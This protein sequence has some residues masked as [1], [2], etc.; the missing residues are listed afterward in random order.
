M[1]SLFFTWEAYCKHRFHVSCIVTSCNLACGWSHTRHRCL[2][3]ACIV[4]LVCDPLKRFHSSRLDFI[5]HFNPVGGDPK[6]SSQLSVRSY[7][8]RDKD[9]VSLC[10]LVFELCLPVGNQIVNLGGYGS[11]TDWV[12]LLSTTIKKWLKARVHLLTGAC[13]NPQSG[14]TLWN[15]W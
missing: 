5:L 14:L 6:E 9:V 3:T 8:Y 4:A 1:D 11:V 13:Y 10:H 12:Y 15:W 2:Q 7:V